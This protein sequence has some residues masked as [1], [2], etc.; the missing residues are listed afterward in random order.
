MAEAALALLIHATPGDGEVTAGLLRESDAVCVRCHDQEALLQRVDSHVGAILVAEEMLSQSLLTRL[1]ERLTLQ[2]P[3]SDVPVLV[4]A[5]VEHHPGLM[6]ALSGLGNVSLLRRPMSTDAFVST[7]AAAFRARRRQ[8]QVRDLLHQQAEQSRRKDDF[9]AMLA[10]ELRNPLAPIRYAARILK[11]DGVTHEHLR[12]IGD[13]VERQVGH[14]GGIIND[15]LETT[16][17]LRGIIEIRP[18]RVVLASVARD[19]IESAAAFA[20]ERDI[21]FR[22]SLDP[23]VEVMADPTRV[24]QVVDNLIDNAI[25]FSPRRGVIH[26][27]VGRSDNHAT[28][29]VKDEGDGIAPA[30]LP[31]IFEPFIQANQSIDRQRGGLGLGLALVR[32]LV[33]LQ[34]GEVTAHSDGLGRGSCFT[35][36]LPLALPRDEPRREGMTPAAAAPGRSLRIVVAE[37]NIDSAQTLRLLLELSGHEV[38]VVH[39]GIAAVE[40]VRRRR[41]DALVCDIGL[42]GLSGYEVARALRR[43]SRLS[44]VRFIALTGYGSAEDREKAL[45]S[46]FDVHLAKPVDPAVLGEKLARP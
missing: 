39:T 1:A 24:R 46:G 3:W 16:R 7:V 10:H 13:L 34:H 41:P 8:F 31:H 37:D 30:L 38:H 25:K 35:V 19:A 26:V 6:A 40:E 15:L 33:R 14:I 11:A 43:D 21:G 45:S 17:V 22:E 20:E 12:K 9:L 18:Q 36:H 32:N 27:S 5:Q 29:V 23:D 28:L 44:H 42:P 4:V 2:P